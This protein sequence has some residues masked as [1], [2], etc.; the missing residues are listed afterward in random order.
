MKLAYIRETAGLPSRKAQIE[1]LRGAGVEDF[2]D[3][4]PVWIDK[5]AQKR[6]SQAKQATWPEL[7][8]ALRAL[9]EGDEL[10][11]ACA[12]VIGG[13][14]GAVLP[15]LQEIGRRGAKLYD[16]EEGALIAWHP[17]AF[18]V[19]AFAQRTENLTRRLVLKKAREGRIATGALGG[20][21]IKLKGKALEAARARWLDL[22][23]TAKEA[24]DA[25]GVSES[26]MRRLFGPKGTPVFGRPVKGRN[27]GK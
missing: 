22:S 3:E 23:Q 24:S 11:I 2:G 10:V 15:V 17:D 8:E 19:L 1:A 13:S 18:E 16:A 25:T 6:R 21:P 20:A 4:A 9:R 26:T 12:A 5:A 7:T 14:T 27:T